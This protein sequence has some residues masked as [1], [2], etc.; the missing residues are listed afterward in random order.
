MTSVIERPEVQDEAEVE[1]DRPCD[2]IYKLIGCPDGKRC[3]RPAQWD[4]IVS[5]DSGHERTRHWCDECYSAYTRGNIFECALCGPPEIMGNAIA[6]SP[7]H[8]VIAY[9]RSN[10]AA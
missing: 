6:Y 3:A 9:P 1:P 4:A 2:V 5:C 7:L 10:R 8:I